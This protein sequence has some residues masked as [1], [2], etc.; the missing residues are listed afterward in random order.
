MRSA[1]VDLVWHMYVLFVRE[2]CS[3]LQQ[4]ILN[5]YQSIDNLP[6]SVVFTPVWTTTIWTILKD[7]WTG[8][9]WTGNYWGTM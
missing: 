5:V 7:V 9:I 2:R 4:E 1:L 6:T 3:K 8:N